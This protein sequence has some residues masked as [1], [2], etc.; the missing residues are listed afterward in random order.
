MEIPPEYLQ[1]IKDV[2]DSVERVIDGS[3]R[4]SGYVNRDDFFAACLGDIQV[5]ALMEE[6][7]FKQFDP[8]TNMDTIETIRQALYRLSA[9]TRAVIC[10]LDVVK[11][12]S[13]PTYKLYFFLTQRRRLG[14]KSVEVHLGQ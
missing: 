4:S 13:N 10:W 12:F 14:R 11:F 2:F 5:Q 7:A 8:K 3:H 1:L 9:E 6:T